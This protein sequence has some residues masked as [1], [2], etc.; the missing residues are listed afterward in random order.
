MNCDSQISAARA[1]ALLSS[2][3]SSNLKR[4]VFFFLFFGGTDVQPAFPLLFC[5]RTSCF[6]KQTSL[7]H[8]QI[9]F[10]SIFMGSRKRCDDVTA[11]SCFH[12]SWSDDDHW[13][14]AGESPLSWFVA[15]IIPL[16]FSSAPVTTSSPIRFTKIHL[17]NLSPNSKALFKLLFTHLPDFRCFSTIK[18]LKGRARS[19]VAYNHKPEPIANADFTWIPQTLTGSPVI[20][21]CSSGRVPPACKPS[22]ATW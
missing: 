6:K 22:H 13:Q 14:R 16:G 4:S 21:G 11:V 12:I 20:L 10:P 9:L 2:F 7:G 5:S 17:Y 18:G 8:S 3:K 1:R 19:C 15:L